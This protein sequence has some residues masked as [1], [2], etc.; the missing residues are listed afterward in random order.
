M[1]L[2]VFGYGFS[3]PGPY[4]IVGVT[5]FLASMS[6]HILLDGATCT[7]PP[8][9]ILRGY[10]KRENRA[11]L[12][13]VIMLYIVGW[14]VIGPFDLVLHLAP[15]TLCALTGNEHKDEWRAFSWW[16]PDWYLCD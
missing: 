14:P 2:S 3:G 1:F 15:G 8:G 11:D 13:V 10:L 5:T 12:L 16:K 9:G 6:W 7:K 4:I